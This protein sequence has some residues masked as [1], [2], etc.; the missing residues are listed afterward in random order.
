M[1]R[2]IKLTEEQLRNIVSKVIKEQSA[3]ITNSDFINNLINAANSGSNKAMDPKGG[4]NQFTG[5]KSL[6]ISCVGLKSPETYKV[7]KGINGEEFTFYNNGRFKDISDESMGFYVCGSQANIVNL[8]YD[9]NPKAVKY[10]NMTPPPVVKPKVKFVPNEVVPLKFGQS[11][12]NIKMIQASLGVK[13]DGLFYTNTDAAVKKY[14]P[15]Y[16][17]QTGVTQQIFDKILGVVT[18][19]T[20]VSPVSMKDIQNTNNPD[21]ALSNKILGKNQFNS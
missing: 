11:G 4:V 13:P 9:D 12:N 15:E 17:R 14:V 18:K 10:F 6:N 5:Q 2:I 7:I 1:K 20:P 3:P 19:R 8:M 16:N 21:T